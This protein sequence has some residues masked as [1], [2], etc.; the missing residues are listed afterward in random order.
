MPYN[1]LKI[2][3]RNLRKDRFYTI[4]NVTGLAIAMAAFLLIIHYVQFERSYENFYKKADHIYRVTLNMYKDGAFITTDCET[5]P[6]LAPL[7]KS[8]LPEVKDYVRIQRIGLSEV[9]TPQHQA[10]LQER[11]YA[12]DSSMF[13]IFNCE[14]I[15]GDPS[16]ALKGPDDAILTASTARKYFGDRD[17]VGQTLTLRGRNVTVAGIIKDQ[18]GNTHLKYDILLS[19]HFVTELGIDLDSWNSNNNFLY[20]E[21]QPGVNL[22]AF[23]A[24]LAALCKAQTQLRDKIYT[25]EP[26]KDIHLHSKKTFE[27]EVNSDVKTVQFLLIVAFLI[28]LIGT[29]NYVNLTTAR[30]AE[31]LKEASIKKILGASQW[32]LIKQ[33]FAESLIINVLAFSLALV[34]I[35]IAMPFYAGIVGKVAAAGIFT[36]AGFWG[37]S[38]ALFV[39]NGLLSGLYPAYALS[40]AKAVSALSRSFTNALKGGSL[41]KTLVVGQ[42]TI[43]SVVLVASLIVYQQLSY[44]R[45]QNLGM[46]IDQVLV[47]RA[48]ELQHDSTSAPAFKSELQQ[49]SGVQKV[50]MG[51]SMPGQGLEYLSTTSHVTR[52]G[53]NGKSSYNYYLYGIDAD[54]IPT[55]NIKM[56]AGRNFVAGTPNNRELVINEEACKRLGFR[57]PEEAIGQKL[58]FWGGYSTV[59]GVI[60]NYHQRSLKEALLPM[61]HFY[62]NNA[63]GYFALKIKSTDLPHTLAAVEKKWQA[64]FK[65]HPFEY[66][67][68]DEMF[69]QQYQADQRLGEIVNIFSIFTIFIT[70]LG[71]LG[72]TAYNVSRRTREIGIRKVLGSSV[73]GIIHL[74]AR[75]FIRLV[76]IAIIIA[77]PIAWWTMDQWLQDFVYRITIPWWVFITAGGSMIFIA[78]CTIGLQSVKAA[79]MDPVKSLRSE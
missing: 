63:A 51:G 25:A 24:K 48:P 66:Y 79:L 19:F 1:D 77:T 73:S 31:R 47:L 7:L 75:D 9:T 3:G 58:N 22:S 20:L 18:P 29:I 33:F 10:F 62:M 11:I 60:K 37:I 72:L 45:H 6:P 4:I 15:K 52:Q 38:T 16:R 41:R 43:A 13:S 46:N 70:C 17:P 78:L 12:A 44:M 71:L 35:W 67:F 61:I 74:L 54:F 2:A 39:L 65:E 40:S 50:A 28:L 32:L 64:Q 30:S 23:N 56:A 42:F 68:L 55:M 34:L 36:S 26:I 69:N 8:Q 59:V 49:L 53:D 5:H 57:S 76:V 21:M 14:F 27:P